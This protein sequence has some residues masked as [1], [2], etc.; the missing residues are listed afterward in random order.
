M[1]NTVKN[2]STS[3]KKFFLN[4]KKINI[5]STNKKN[6]NKNNVKSSKVMKL[7]KYKMAINDVE[8]L[9]N[10]NINNNIND[11]KIKN[12]LDLKL[13]QNKIQYGLRKKNEKE[14][15]KSNDKNNE[16]N[17]EFSF[18]R[19]FFVNNYYDDNVDMKQCENNND[20]INFVNSKKEWCNLIQ[21]NIITNLPEFE[22]NKKIYEE[23]YECDTPQ[24]TT[25]DE[26]KL[27]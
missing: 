2:L 4:K 20:I 11:K 25:L 5:T 1:R 23:N 18:N 24:F 13:I 27:N 10:N 14:K 12:I 17:G 22:N 7:K 15:K 3:Y 6:N 8:C 26:Q 9:N 16:Y 19:D 21:S